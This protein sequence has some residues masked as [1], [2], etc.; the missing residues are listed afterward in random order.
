MSVTLDRIT[1]YPIKSLPGIEV[2]EATVLP[3]GALAEDRRFA[4]VDEAGMFVN[5]KRFAAI[6]QVQATYSDQ[7]Q[8]VLLTCGGQHVSFLLTRDQ[9][10]IGSW[11]SQVLG[12]SCHLEENGSGGFPDDTDAPG[13]TLITTASLEMVAGW[14]EGISLAEARLRF[15]TNLEVGGTAPFWEDRLV[16]AADSGE[17]FIIGET[18]WRGHTVCQRCAV[19]TRDSRTGEVVP[20]FARTFSSQRENRL[21]DWAPREVFDHFYRLAIN[22]QRVTAS[23]AAKQGPLVLRVGDR[24]EEMA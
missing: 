4:L 1:I 15:R 16:A 8:R 24:V 6:Q 14:Y 18:R 10:A 2:A 7:M 23:G 9:E 22:T 21:P 13:P 20:H 17:H 19:P 11:F 3:S 12:I 5:G